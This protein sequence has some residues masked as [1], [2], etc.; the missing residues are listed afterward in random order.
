MGPDEFGTV[1]KS[2]QFHLAFTR[3]RSHGT[4]QTGRIDHLRNRLNFDLNK[5]RQK[6][7]HSLKITKLVI[8]QIFGSRKGTQGCQSIWFGRKCCVSNCS[9]AIVSLCCDIHGFRTKVHQ[10]AKN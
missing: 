9:F 6:F 5:S 4:H 10:V 2:I 7:H 8:F 1:L 3:A